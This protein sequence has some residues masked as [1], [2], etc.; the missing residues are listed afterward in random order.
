MIRAGSLRR[1]TMLSR[2]A[3]GGKVSKIFQPAHP[4]ENAGL[5]RG[6]E[7]SVCDLW[8]RSRPFESVFNDKYTVTFL[9]LF[10][11]SLILIFFC[12]FLWSRVFW[13]RSFLLLL[14]LRGRRSYKFSAQIGRG[15]SLLFVD[16][17]ATGNGG[18]LA[19]T[20]FVLARGIQCV[21][22]DDYTRDRLLLFMYRY[23]L[24]TRL[25]TRL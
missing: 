6:R 25:I 16:R 12:C 1:V 2:H 7:A 10:F 11:S 15:Y 19:L 8:V 5:S 17:A 18:R 24:I 9:L 20:R 23:V 22:T 4:Q 13:S 14:L 3:P 21:F